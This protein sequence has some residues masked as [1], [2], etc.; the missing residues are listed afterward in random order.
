[1][2]SRQGFLS[3]CSIY[4]VECKVLHSLKAMDVPISILVLQF[5]ARFC[6]PYFLNFS[7]R[8]PKPAGLSPS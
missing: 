1:M 4:V 6:G 7:R 8:V 5:D 2:E 3:F